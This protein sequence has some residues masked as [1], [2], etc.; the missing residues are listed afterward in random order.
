[1]NLK[2]IELSPDIIEMVI[3]HELCHS[4]YFDHGANFYALMV[5]KLPHY[6]AIETQLRQIEK[7]CAY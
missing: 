7:N 4:H 1:L 2:L 6:K 3:V 5:E